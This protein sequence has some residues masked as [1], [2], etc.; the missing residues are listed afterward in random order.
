MFTQARKYSVAETRFSFEKK[1]QAG[2]LT[3]VFGEMVDES[4]HIPI[5][6]LAG[7][8]RLDID[9]GKVTTLNS[10]GTRR[11]TKW[12]WDV[13]NQSADL[14][15]SMRNVSPVVTKQLL[16][17]Y[18][19]VPDEIEIKSVLVPHYCETCDLEDRSCLVRAVDV[20]NSPDPQK[21]LPPPV[22][23]KTCQNNMEIDVDPVKYFAL[24]TRD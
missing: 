11:L 7:Y 22:R 3:L 23:C 18:G 9:L 10:E 24:L 19:F 2:E 16:S 20:E 21:F 8:S 17:L 15:I 13:H 6:E 1:E 12:L 14:K 5:S 4:F